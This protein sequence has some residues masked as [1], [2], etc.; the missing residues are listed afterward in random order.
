MSE[1]DG[2]TVTPP[3]DTFES[4]YALFAASLSLVGLGTTVPSAGADHR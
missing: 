3:E 2:S 1:S 4:T